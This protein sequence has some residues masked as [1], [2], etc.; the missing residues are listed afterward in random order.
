MENSV[1][2]DGLPVSDE[3]ASGPHP[4]ATLLLLNLKLLRILSDIWSHPVDFIS[5]FPAYRVEV[6]DKWGALKK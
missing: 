2:K 3:L 5:V 4:L 6:T 1:F